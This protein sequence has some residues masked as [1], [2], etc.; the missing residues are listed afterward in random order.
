MLCT[1]FENDRINE[2]MLKT[3]QYLSLRQILEGTS[4]LKWFPGPYFNAKSVF[5][6]IEIHII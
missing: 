3:L 5:S 4:L 2:R 6:S 1:K